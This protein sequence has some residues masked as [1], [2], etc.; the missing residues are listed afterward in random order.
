[1][2]YLF[3]KDGD[4]FERSARFRLGPATVSSTAEDKVLQIL[5]YGCRGARSRHHSLLQV[6][7]LGVLKFS[8]LFMLL[9]SS[10]QSCYCLHTSQSH[11]RLFP[12]RPSSNMSSSRL[13]Q[14]LGLLLFY[15]LAYA[16]QYSFGIQDIH[17]VLPR[18]FNSNA[19]LLAN[20]L[21]GSSDANNNTWTLGQ[22]KRTK[23]SVRVTSPK[24]PKRSTFRPMQQ[25]YLSGLVFRTL[26]TPLG[27]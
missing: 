22:V 19:L 18:D 9:I 1:V 10:I 13:Q 24:R 23:T 16:G 5:A 4:S 27:K 2:A 6:N 11:P 25:T 26:P 12:I 14:L 20:A 21:S 7:H 3:V 17:V 8:L 15:N